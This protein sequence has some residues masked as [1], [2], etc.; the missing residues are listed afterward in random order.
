MRKTQVAALFEE[1]IEEVRKKIGS[2]YV[3]IT[4]DKTTDARRNYIANLLIG[5]LSLHEGGAPLLIASSELEKTNAATVSTFVNDSLMRFYAGKPFSDRILLLVTDAAPY[6]YASSWDQFKTFY[7]NLI[8]ITCVAHGIHRICE[9]VREIFPNMNRLISSARKIFLKCPS[10]C[11]VYKQHMN[12]PLPPDV[13]VTRWGTWVNAAIFFATHYENFK[14]VMDALP[15][16]GSK[17]VENVK[18]LLQNDKL[19]ADLAFINSYLNFLPD[20]IKKLESRG[21]SLNTQLAMVANVH[22]KISQIPGSR[23]SI[24]RQKADDVFTK[25]TGLLLL[26]DVN[27]SLINGTAPP[28]MMSPA[29]LSAYVFAPIVSVEVERSFSEYK[30]VLSDRRHSFKQENLEKHLVVQHNTKFL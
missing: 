24:L 30:A 29:L 17:Y 22:L 13:V 26:E 23:G 27:N 5:N 20:A 14:S 11:D 28:P 3:Y 9:K 16:D 2:N 6:T 21:L 25:N 12:C 8:H 1:K 7:C 19:A 4:I 15:N 10:R 18:S